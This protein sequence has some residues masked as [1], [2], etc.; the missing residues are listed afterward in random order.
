M[1]CQFCGQEIS[2]RAAREQSAQAVVCDWCGRRQ[3]SAPAEAQT[4]GRT[5]PFS[6]SSAQP[7]AVDPQPPA[8]TRRAA[9]AAREAELR[10]IAATAGQVIGSDRPLLIAVVLIGIGAAY[11]LYSMLSH[12]AGGSPLLSVVSSVLSFLAL[13]G[14]LTLRKWG[15]WLNVILCGVSSV[16]LVLLVPTMF[17][18]Q[19][20]LTRVIA[21]GSTAGIVAGANS[22]A[23]AV[24]FVIVLLAMNLF[25]IRTLLLRQEKFG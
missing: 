10:A 21:P 24:V 17:L 18:A 20:F 12:A 25:V 4:P 23:A 3:E 11:S 7:E 14:A 16:W 9:P 6:G 8:A 1:K 5:L 13:L 2:L 15:L 19:G 22:I